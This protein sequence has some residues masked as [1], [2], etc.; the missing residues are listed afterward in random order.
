MC[1]CNA[2]SASP[3]VDSFVSGCRRMRVLHNIM[4]LVWMLWQCFELLEP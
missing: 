2:N 1:V 4:Q 3:D